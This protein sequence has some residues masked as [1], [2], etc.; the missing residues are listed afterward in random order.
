[1]AFGEVAFSGSR[2]VFWGTAPFLLGGA[3]A[4]PLSVHDWTLQKALLVTALST[5]CICALFAL[6]DAQR[7]PWA[8]RTLTG[9]VFAAYAGYLCDELLF[10]NAPI[11]PTRR[12]EASPWNSIVGFAVI[13]LPALWYTLLGRFTLRAPLPPDPECAGELDGDWDDG[14]DGDEDD[15]EAHQATM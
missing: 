8:A 6:R 11:V 7:Y 13:G 3:F 1:M 2:F 15:D 14:F 9:L 10:S 12:S 5:A 4:I